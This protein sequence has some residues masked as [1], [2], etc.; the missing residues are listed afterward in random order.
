MADKPK[1]LAPGVQRSG[2]ATMSVGYV[3]TSDNAAASGSLESWRAMATRTRPFEVT[4]GSVFRLAVPMTLAYLSTPLVGAVL[5]LRV[6]DHR[7]TAPRTR[8]APAQ[9]ERQRTVPAEPVSLPAMRPHAAAPLS[10][11]STPP[12]PTHRLPHPQPQLVA[13]AADG[14]GGYETPTP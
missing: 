5:T 4:H 7:H 8:P 1:I 10:P 2:E 12:H 14:H 9:P 6:L 11:A 3:T 13:A